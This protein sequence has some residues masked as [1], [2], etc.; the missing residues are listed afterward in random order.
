MAEGKQADRLV[1]GSDGEDEI[2]T[3]FAGDGFVKRGSR[4]ELSAAARQGDAGFAVAADGNSSS[5]DQETPHDRPEQV[6]QQGVKL[7]GAVEELGGF[8][9]GFQAR[10]A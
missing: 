10:F 4:D 7:Q 8:K 5:A 1:I 6:A 3:G 9:Q 2:E